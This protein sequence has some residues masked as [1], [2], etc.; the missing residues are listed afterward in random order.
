MIKYQPWSGFAE[1]R[2]ISNSVNCPTCNELCT[3]S[4]Y[5]SQDGFRWRCFRHNFT[6]ILFFEGAKVSLDTAIVLLYCW[7]AD[8]LQL[9]IQR[10]TLLSGNSVS[11]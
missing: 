1:R 4:Q 11:L 2:L 6:Q 9:Q 3:L 5:N 10:E 8:F 7:A